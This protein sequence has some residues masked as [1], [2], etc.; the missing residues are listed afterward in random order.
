MKPNTAFILAAGLGTRLRPYT[1]HCPK[2]MV[3]VA[4]QSLIKRI[5]K[6]LANEDIDN[7]IINKHYLANKLETHLS[8][9]TH[10]KLTLLHEDELKDTGGGIKSGL[11]H[12]GDQP[13]YAIN[14]DSLCVDHA[15]QDTALT[16][17]A[18]NWDDDKMDIFLLLQKVEDMKLTAG[19][20]DYHLN[21]DGTCTRALD[22]KGDYMFSSIR[23][24]H[25][26]IFEKTPDTSF[27]FLQLMD[28]AQ[29]E[30]RLYGLVHSGDWH[31]ISTAQDLET[32]NKAMSTK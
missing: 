4:G 18:E 26:R 25:P 30:G 7:I 22:K 16:R 10:P 11:K 13:F 27:S 29:Q 3:E 23:I 15:G 5:I 2:P 1:D 21:A 32:V 19:V 9:I 6:Q 14:G 24:A 20:G 17:L 8:D 28:K 31:H 12:I